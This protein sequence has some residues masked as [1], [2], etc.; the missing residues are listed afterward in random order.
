MSPIVLKYIVNSSKAQ[1][2]CILLLYKPALT[3]C[4]HQ[5]LH[6]ILIIL[7]NSDRR[8][9]CTSWYLVHRYAN[10]QNI[11]WPSSLD[12]RYFSLHYKLSEVCVGTMSNHCNFLFFIFLIHLLHVALLLA[13]CIV[14]V[15]QWTG[16]TNPGIWI[17]KKKL[18]SVRS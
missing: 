11:N 10:K 1:L 2:K 3:T 17:C 16:G 9:G 6:Y 13:H 5:L 4:L 15:S 14:R 7:V 18:K 8:L 12:F